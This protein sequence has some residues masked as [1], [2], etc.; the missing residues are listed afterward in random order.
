MKT[1]YLF[2]LLIFS[3]ACGN[4]TNETYDLAGADYEAIME[5]PATRQ[6][7]PQSP[8]ITKKF[9]KTSGID[10]ET[11]NVEATYKT[12][13]DLLPTFEAYI[14]NENQSKTSQSIH[15]NL[16]IRVPSSFHDSLYSSIGNLA[17]KLDSKYSNI[18][19]VTERY[20]DLKLRIKNK[21]ALEERYLD[22]LK[23]A[24][25][26]KDILEIEKNLNEI[27]IN[28][29]QLQGQFNYLSKQV[30][31]STIQ[32]SFYETLPYVYD[33]SQRK[34]FG[35]RVLS[36]L[37]NGWQGFLSFLVGVTTLWPFIIVLFAGVYLFRKMRGKWKTK[38]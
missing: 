12:I 6:S 32:L 33:S 24:T 31:L 4:A 1:V 21:K 16:T 38:K 11:E 26:V 3:F 36:G 37:N 35:A 9:I 23:K 27:R 5:A 14:E 29:E 20:Y 7:A 28:I 2:S 25:A 15:Y 13:I 10:F 34:G 18:E 22:L 30:N 17:F 8:T 19:D